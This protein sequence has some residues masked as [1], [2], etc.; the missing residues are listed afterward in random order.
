MKIL[1]LCNKVPYPG[2][3]GSSLAMEALIRLEVKAGHEVHVLALNTDKHFVPHPQ[4]PA[5]IVFEAPAVRVSP[6]LRG[7]LGHLLHPASYF[8]ARFD[9]AT[10]RHRIWVLAAQ[11]D[12]IVVDS[13]FMAVY[14]VAF[15]S[16]PWILRAHNVEHQIWERTL[17]GMPWSPKKAFTA[18][19]TRRL[20]RWES[21]MVQGAKVWAISQ[22]DAEA[23]SRLGAK[24]VRAL[25]CTYD[26]DGPWASSGAA[27]SGVYH[28]GALDWLPNVQGLQWYLEQVHPLVH[29]PVTVISRQWPSQLHAP[30]GLTHLPRLEDGFS[31]DD[32]GIFIAPIL[33]GSGMRIKLLEAMVRGKAIVTTSIGA[34]GLQNAPGIAVANDPVAFAEAIQRLVDDKDFRMSQGAAAQ[35]H[36]RATFADDAFVA[37]LRAL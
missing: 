18:W 16:T 7:L 14:C 1:H 31:F 4:A 36:A 27:A 35:A 34:E 19:Q 5:G 32:H 10:V 24:S 21:L 6:S 29:V 9:H 8:A 25:P 20:K 37:S 26:V 11:A 28:L 17:A 2:R 22:E 15:G 13:L 30:S 23:L 3:D 12:L 33:S